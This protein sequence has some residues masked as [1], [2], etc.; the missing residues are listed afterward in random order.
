MH[1]ASHLSVTVLVLLLAAFT[2]GCAT[3]MTRPAAEPAKPLPNP[4]D[5]MRLPWAPPGPAFLRQW[6][7]CGVFP[8]PVPA[9]A[10]AP[11]PGSGLD[12][13][14]LKDAGGE[15]AIRPTAKMT[16]K[17]PD[18]TEAH[19]TALDSAENVIDLLKAFP[20]QPT[21]NVIAYAY[22]TV[23][24]PK[25][26][27]VLMALGS[28]DG[29]RVWLNGE[30]IHTVPTPR[31]ITVDGDRIP[32]HMK[33]GENRLLVKVEQ[34]SG[35]WGFCVR[36]LDAG[37]A[38]VALGESI[39]PAIVTGPT[40]A[41][42]TLTVRTDATAVAQANAAE[43]AATVKVEI[44]APG[45]RAIAEKDAPRGQSVAFR[46]AEWADGPYEV[47]CTM[48]TSAGKRKV[49][50]LPWF[51]GDWVAAA[52][53]LANSKPPAKLD[54]S[55][56]LTRN[57]LSGFACEHMSG[58]ILR[59]GDQID[60]SLHAAL[61]EAAELND[62][63]S[64][65]P[66]GVH[67]YGFVRL[68]WL[69]PIDEAPQFCRAYLPA[70]YDAG[71]RWPLVV[72]LHGYN[73]E[74]PPYTRSWEFDRRH[75]AWSDD[76]N[77]IVIE[78]HGRGNTGYEGLGELDVLRAIAE[79]K[80]RFAVDDD[81][82]YLVG[83]SMGGGGTWHIGTRHA[84]LF[85]G[86][87]PVF[88][89]WDWHVYATPEEFAAMTPAEKKTRE[90]QSSF[91]GVE[92][93]LNTP[94]FVN[95]G[96]DDNLVSVENSRYVVRMLQ[97]WGYDVRYWEHPGLG[98]GPLG[99]EEAVITWMLEH[100]REANPAHVRLRALELSGA[101]AHWVQVTQSL[102]PGQF[103]VVDA[104]IIGPN[105]VRLDT[106]N[107]QALTLRPEGP[108]INASQPLVVVWNGKTQARPFAG[109]RV[110][111]STVEGLPNALAKTAAISGP[112]GDAVNTPFTI[113]LGTTSKDPL[114]RRL[115]EKQAEAAVENWEKWQH[116]RPRYFRDTNVTD[117]MLSKY[118]FILIGG[119][120]DNALVNKLVNQGPTGMP[121]DGLKIAA[122]AVT[123]DGRRFPCQDAAVAIIRPNPFNLERYV[124]V[125]AGTSAK[126]MYW[127]DPLPEDV[128]FVIED[129]RAAPEVHG[130]PVAEVRVA[131]GLFDNAWHIQDALTVV[132]TAAA[133]QAAPVRKAPT[134][135]T[136]RSNDQTLYLADL[137]ETA[138]A[139]TFATMR[140]DTNWDYAPMQLAGRKFT[141]GIAVQT[142]HEPSTVDYDIDGAGWRRLRGTIGIEVDHPERLE[143]K[144]KDNTRVVFI[145]KGDEKELF[146]S[147]PFRWDGGPLP[148][149]VD[150]T[151]VRTLRLEV[152][153]ETAWFCAAT[154]VD[155]ADIR[156]E[157]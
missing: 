26:E 144:H 6:Q 155:W 109:G 93:L 139:G 13:D 148:L 127:A 29:V 66:G 58:Y 15:A 31:G 105:T 61:M 37:G 94:V 41:A 146:R 21:T 81:R 113:V 57:M 157:K 142:A 3:L 74:N 49:V 87:V 69:D 107:V 140:R 121:M 59:G 51:K 132:G 70:D 90:K 22:T 45:G 76:H 84:G 124:V 104:E 82:V 83:Y 65:G 12:I 111:L 47:R 149:D 92:S 88:G 64:G 138:A 145:V 85:A 38:A 115:C 125:K 147:A 2:A 154:S 86:I 95:H 68:A 11:A 97:R 129:G 100:K 39:A 40:A 17:R 63:A 110:V 16:V 35:D 19:W 137:L 126:G 101:T 112:I 130:L 7:V 120:D 151:G 50:H 62:A 18:G 98:H 60:A 106:E 134:L 24:W 78:P 153:N 99:S 103:I 53:L 150:V 116:A 36:L 55:A 89:G 48:M 117:D 67:P 46:T 42:D 79:A 54:A 80:K 25:D 28:D 96:A 30:R 141:R 75:S 52:A 5:E 108:S 14:Y 77:A 34:G 9:G 143:P 10:T 118:S 71:K 119:P 1:P 4:R 131:S 43:P 72:S 152:M 27:Q 114:M 91:R 73:A 122:D 128:D 136:A 135:A 56:S 133:R 123:I 102:T 44:I 156:L 20:D 8:I 23:T 32:V 33:A